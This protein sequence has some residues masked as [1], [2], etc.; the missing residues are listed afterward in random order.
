MPR[1]SAARHP[2]ATPPAPPAITPPA[3][4]TQ[5]PAARE[6]AL[7][8]SL[9]LHELQKLQEE[10]KEHPERF[11]IEDVPLSDIVPSPFN[12]KDR[13]EAPE[14]AYQDIL[15]SIKEFGV[16]SPA[17]IIRRSTLI[18]NSPHLDKKT[19]PG[20]Y[21]YVM[22]HRRSRASYF[23]GLKTIP[24]VIRDEW[25]TAKALLQIMLAEN[26]GR[27][28][29]KPIEEGRG[30]RLLRD[31]EKMSLQ[32]I[33]DS[34]GGKSRGQISKRIKLTELTALGE[35]LLN[36]ELISIDAALD[37][38]AK[39]PGDPHRQDVALQAVADVQADA[40]A[41]MPEKEVAK[42]RAEALKSAIERQV[43]ELKAAE[44]DARL[45][46]EVEAQGLPVIDP[47]AE[48]G[49]DFAAHRVGADDVE[50]A[51]AAGK[52]VGAAVEM[53]EVAY[54]AESPRAVPPASP[55]VPAAAVDDP[56]GS[57]E[58]P[59][60]SPVSSVSESPGESAGE[61]ETDARQEP[62]TPALAEHA[63]AT[64]SRKMA[65]RRVIEDFGRVKEKNRNHLIDQLSDGVLALFR[66][67]LPDARLV[68]A[69]IADWTGLD[70]SAV[71][72]PASRG[73]TQRIALAATLAAL[74]QEASK[75]K[76]ATTAWPAVVIK[77]V[78]RLVSMGYHELTEYEASKIA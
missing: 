71:E 50:S 53:G 40:P 15:P 66:R 63:A 77:Y 62:V 76:Y 7:E 78:N 16:F 38:L 37:L 42:R 8:Q 26:T 47:S 64:R 24:A 65:C 6:S 3:P 68:A 70:A 22:G 17:I 46:E 29:L 9:R 25:A 2:S 58:S 52:I 48:F 18:A 61:S 67:D 43:R 75:E 54:Y 13:Q 30:Y 41:E 60:Q 23:A 59:A 33:L 73:D 31:V 4:V 1:N 11:K 34:T 55:L 19:D 57:N 5:V 32:E 44:L 45:R 27:T 49:D 56:H 14:S 74:E 35:D 36:A 28:P 20:T 72:S 21:V 69:D 10:I 39:L 12:P 51:L